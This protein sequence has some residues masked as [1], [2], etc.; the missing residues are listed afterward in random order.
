[1]KKAAMVTLTPKLRQ[2]L[3]PH[4]M[5]Q[6]KAGNRICMARITANDDKPQ[7]DNKLLLNHSAAQELKLPISTYHIYYL[8]NNQIWIGPVVAVM[9]SAVNKNRH[10]HGKTGKMLRELIQYA[11][12]RGIFVYLFGLDG[13][14]RNLHQ[15]RG[16]SIIN[17]SWQPGLFPW[18]DIIYNRI[19]LRKIEK[20]PQTNRLLRQI[21]LDRRIHFFNSRFLNKREVYE[22]LTK[23]PD[24]RSI[25]PDTRSFS[26]TNLHSMLK[27][28]NEIFMKP[29]HGSIGK[30]IY[31]IKMLSPGLYSYAGT[32]SALPVWKG[33]YTVEV[34]FR[35]L[36]CNAG[37]KREYLLQQAIKLARYK[38]RIFD[39]RSQV[40]KNHRGE[41]I[42]TG[43]AV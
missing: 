40:Q 33:P 11:Q 36:Q 43:A 42:L 12:S 17:N 10:P 7:D 25:I 9:P 6:I 13:I 26:R 35:H 18:P 16:I 38:S 29:N 30:G 20:L 41:W 31:K 21:N 19:R 27:I 2:E 34:L 22:A 8:D 37:I 23:H 32:S 5:A 1:M 24:T 14:Q 28:H 39:V 15:I 3:S 4:T